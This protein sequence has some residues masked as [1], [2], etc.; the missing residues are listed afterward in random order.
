MASSTTTAAA[1]RKY[2]FL[3][4]A[5]DKPD[6]RERRLAARGDHFN[7]M[8]PKVKSGDWKV[9]GALLNDVPKDDEVSSLDF[10]GSTL[11][12]EATSKEEVLEILKNDPYGKADVWDFDKVQIYPFRQAWKTTATI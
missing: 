11:V 9:G 3:V 4:I 12:I 8:V 1:G 10:F 5:P 6:A 2:D 7:G